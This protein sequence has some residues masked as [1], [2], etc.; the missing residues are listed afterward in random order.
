VLVPGA[1]GWL[2]LGAAVAT[3]AA[4]PL[5]AALFLLGVEYAVS[6][7]VRGGSIDALAPAVGAVLFA[8]AE[9]SYLALEPEA[10]TYERAL[11]TRRLATIA[12]AGLVAG[13]VGAIA[14]TASDF[15]LGGGVLLEAVG[16]VSAVGAVGAAAVLAWRRREEPS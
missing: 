14:V 10:R 16:V 15:A 9:L 2:L 12:I 11:M 6:L 1:A 3:G 5:P 13:A 7:L 8:T 4:A